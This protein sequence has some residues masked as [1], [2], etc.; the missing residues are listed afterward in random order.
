MNSN[1]FGEWLR[2]QLQRREWSQA[3]FVRRGQFSRTAVSDWILGKRI[4]DPRSS[5]LIADVLG[6]D[7]DEVLALAGHREPDEP[8]E[9][10][11][12]RRELLTLVRMLR[13]TPDRAVGLR[14][15]IRGWI[16]EDR[17]QGKAGKT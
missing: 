14:H 12:P 2:K 16:D 13:V 7:R 9:A 8:I 3:D 6:V 15:L 1:E 5:D 17:R 11:D 4:P 10:D